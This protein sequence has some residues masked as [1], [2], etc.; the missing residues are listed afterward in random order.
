MAPVL[1]VAVT[2]AGVLVGVEGVET[3]L[4]LYV[5]GAVGAEAA[6]LVREL[7][8][9]RPSTA[10]TWWSTAAA[11][12]LFVF[13]STAVFAQLEEAI[14]RIWNQGPRAD[15]GGVQAQLRTRFVSFCLVLATG[16][17]LVVSAIARGIMLFLG[18]RLASVVPIPG[19]VLNSLDLAV[20]A[21]AF[22]PLAML[23]FRVLPTSKIEWRDAA[24]GAMASG[25]LLLV[26]QVAIG[27]YLGLA[28]PGSVYGAAGSVVVLLFWIYYSAMI[29]LW[30]AALTRTRAEHREAGLA[31]P[32]TGP[33]G[34]A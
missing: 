13:G 18:E 7:L 2:V 12:A 17:V 32:D 21:I 4:L 34:S 30:G 27:A 1:V 10:S 5:E 15:G 33:A 11:G 19:V 25:V 16:G 23:I 29:F 3:R 28:A 22:L 20:F 31:P 9:H 24:W 6:S 8:A 14:R 26:G